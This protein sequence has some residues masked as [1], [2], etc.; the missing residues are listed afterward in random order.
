VN[1]PGLDGNPY[2]PLLEKN[3]MKGFSSLMSFVIKGNY[4][5]AVKFIDALKVLTHATHLGT[6]RSIV[7]HPA[8]T[9]HSAMGEAEM[10]KAGI[11]PAM[12]RFSIGLE[13]KEDLLADIEQAL[14]R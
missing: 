12:V 9:T 11:S 8:S 6:C 4:A 7:T 5:D 3:K 10:R 2:H 13:E 14:N 1:Y